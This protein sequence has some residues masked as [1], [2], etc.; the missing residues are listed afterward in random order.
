M[1]NKSMVV[2]SMGKRLTAARL[3]KGYASAAKFAQEIQVKPHTYRMYERGDAFPKLVI[4]M[5]ICRSL[6]IT[7]NDLLTDN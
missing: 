4:L 5:R 2:L 7:P 6:D 3:L 1:N